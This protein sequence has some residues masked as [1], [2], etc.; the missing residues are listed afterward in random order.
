MI[1]SFWNILYSFNDELHYFIPVFA[2]K[3]KAAGRE[4]LCPSPCGFA[5]KSWRWVKHRQ[6]GITGV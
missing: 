2:V 1:P 3:K 4:L 6:L 5:K